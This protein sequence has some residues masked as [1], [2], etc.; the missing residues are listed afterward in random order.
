[1][2]TPSPD[3]LGPPLTVPLDASADPHQTGIV[4]R[5]EVRNHADD[6]HDLPMIVPPMPKKPTASFHDILQKA[7]LLKI[8]HPSALSEYV[9]R[10]MSVSLSV[11][12]AAVMSR[13][14]A[15]APTPAG[16]SKQPPILPP[17]AMTMV[18]TYNSFVRVHVNQNRME[19]VDFK[20]LSS[21]L[22]R[23]AMHCGFEIRV[24]YSSKRNKRWECREKGRWSNDASTQPAVG[25]PFVLSGYKNK[26]NKIH[27]TDIELMHVH[28]GDP[29][30]SG[31][32]P[33]EQSTAQPATTDTDAA[34]DDLDTMRSSESRLTRNTTLSNELVLAG[35]FESDVG[36]AIILKD[37]EELKLKDIQGILLAQFGAQISASMASRAKRKLV[38]MFYETS[39][40]SYQ[41]LRPFF[42]KLVAANPTSF[43][44]MDH[45]PGSQ[46]EI[47]EYGRCMLGVGPALH[48]VPECAPVLVLEAC[49]MNAEMH[50]SGVLLVLSTRDYNSDTVL[51]ALAHVPAADLHNW[52]WFLGR[53]QANGL[54]PPELT[55]FVSDGSR[56]IAQAVHQVYPK[57]PHRYS[58]EHMIPLITSTTSMGRLGPEVE[59][60]IRQ[61]A[62]S[63]NMDRYMEA[64]QVIW[65]IDRDLGRYLEGIPKEH[66]VT[67]AVLGR[68]WPLLKE[69][70]LKTCVGEFAKSPLGALL[71]SCNLVP[72]FYLFALAIQQTLR[73]RAAHTRSLPDRQLLP[74]QHATLVQ[75]TVESGRYE[76]QECRHQEVYFAQYHTVSTSSPAFKIVNIVART[77]TCGEWQPF[78]IP[79]VHA[80]A[81]LNSLPKNVLEYVH[82][83][84]FTGHHKATYGRA[85]PVVPVPPI[86]L[87]LDT[88]LTA[89]A[90]VLQQIEAAQNAAA[91]LDPSVRSKPGPRP[92]KRKEMAT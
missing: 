46:D 27:V 84:Y 11:P 1:M 90:A 60:L 85:G 57:H 53:L 41:L 4:D 86:D 12:P 2:E 51:L 58:I 6:E 15:V 79:C 49:A 63:I 44:V 23:L 17:E 74:A 28:D 45:V 30:P 52:T 54:V 16:T 26:D 80:I 48:L 29:L 78:H 62:E 83:R 33:S 40:A 76:V 66:W 89:P 35:V 67:A 19:F 5:Q 18:S 88:T 8:I 43:Y 73:D 25:C 71:R 31:L 34:G 21:A 3:A 68:G 69:V 9:S 82:D 77:C 20:Q 22:K 92:R 70:S 42:D 24:K 81:V 14:A 13:A 56:D 91:P 87:K 61:M 75:R 36:Q 38:E 32:V 10:T 65:R 37:P 7:V 72:C 47:F 64:F 59:H 39:K 55:T 50:K